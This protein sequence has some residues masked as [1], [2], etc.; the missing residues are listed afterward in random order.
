M[1][2]RES[3]A[4]ARMALLWLYHQAY[5]YHTDFSISLHHRDTGH[6]CMASSQH[7][8]KLLITLQ[9]IRNKSMQQRLVQDW[10]DCEQHL[11]NEEED[12][13]DQGDVHGKGRPPEQ[14]GVR[15]PCMLEQQRRLMDCFRNKAQPSAKQYFTARLIYLSMSK[16]KFNMAQCLQKSTH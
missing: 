16:A 13:C 8:K 14:P 5:T 12:I 2:T 15:L 1:S 7:T 4:E 11:C 9:R 6:I 10:I 3:A